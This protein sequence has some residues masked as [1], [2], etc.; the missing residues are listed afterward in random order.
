[1][2]ETEVFKQMI[3]KYFNQNERTGKE[4][5]EYEKFNPESSIK[6]V[7]SI[8]AIQKKLG[9][10]F[11]D[12]YVNFLKAEGLGSYLNDCGEDLFIY[13]E[14]DLYEFN[15]TPHNHGESAFEELQGYLLFGQDGGECSY[16]FDPSNLLGFGTD[17]VYRI[18]RDVLEKEYFEL[19]AKDFKE[20]FSFFIENKE[21]PT[22]RP[23]YTEPEEPPKGKGEAIVQRI[24]QE[25]QK[26]PD[27]YKKLQSDMNQIK[28]YLEF[29]DSKYT[30]MDSDYGYEYG[31]NMNDKDF[32][33]INELEVH[34]D[35]KLPIEYLYL[36]NMLRGGYYRSPNL[37]LEF[38]AYD[39]LEFY[40]LSKK[41]NKKLSKQLVFANIPLLNGI[42]YLVFLDMNN[43]LGNGSSAIYMLPD[44]A[45]KLTEASFIA[46]D[47]VDL[48]RLIAENQKLNTEPIG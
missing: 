34:F 26:E 36:L 8:P 39:G 9:Y 1:M 32:Y 11:P 31:Y 12:Q 19:L 27:V 13:N 43:I 22:T 41:A 20:F 15:Y 25:A 6:L 46:K 5:K 48:F 44:E 7:E 16:F 47:F 14:N 42:S 45:K 18:D 40:N 28:S 29:I 35:R 21:L 4:K 24:Q 10:T 30:N 3:T 33:I 38:S 37:F 23:F 17:A 2:T